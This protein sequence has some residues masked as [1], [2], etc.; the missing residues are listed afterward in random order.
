MIIAGWLWLRAM[1][2]LVYKCVPFALFDCR[3]VAPC[4]SCCYMQPFIDCCICGLR[5]HCAFHV[6]MTCLG[7]CCVSMLFALCAAA[8]RWVCMICA[9]FLRGVMFCVAP[10]RFELSMF[11]PDDLVLLVASMC[12]DRGLCLC[13]CVLRCADCVLCCVIL[14]GTPTSVISLY[15][16]VLYGVHC[17]GCVDVLCNDAACHSCL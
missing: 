6:C 8:L 2:R 5:L 1:L 4:L 9:L 10:R 16:D 13:V 12:A 3:D 15:R 14:H 7:V 11:G 17:I